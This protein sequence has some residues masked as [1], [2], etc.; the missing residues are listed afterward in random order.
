MAESGANNLTG[1]LLTP[2]PTR[3][4]AFSS[5]ALNFCSA[6][7]L[8]PQLSILNHI[9]TGT[10]SPHP[11]VIAKTAQPSAPEPA[12]SITTIST[13]TPPPSSQ[14][15]IASQLTTASAILWDPRYTTRPLPGKLKPTHA[16]TLAVANRTDSSISVRNLGGGQ[17]IPTIPIMDNRRHPSSFQ[18]LEKLG[19]GTYATACPTL[20]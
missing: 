4:R 5:L 17:T 18:Q 13:S 3:S 1:R 6:A 7:R 12:R 9:V 16:G 10:R 14:L 15:H 19:E 2:P 8:L 20:P 11:L